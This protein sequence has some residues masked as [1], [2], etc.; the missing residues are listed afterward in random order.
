M[1]YQS[2]KYPEIKEEDRTYGAAISGEVLR[3][4]GDWRP[5]TPPD[6]NQNIRGIE[7][8]ACYVEA[9]QASIASIQE[10]QFDILDQN[11]SARFN[12]LLSGGDE[13]GGDPLKG[14]LSIKKDGLIPQKMMDFGDDIQSWLDFHSWKGVDKDKCIQEGKNEAS[15]WEKKYKIVAEKE[16]SLE[17][18]YANLREDLKR[19]PVPMS[20]SAWFERDGKY[21]KPKGMRDNH[22]VEALYVDEKNQITIRDTYSPYIKVLEAN[23]DFDFAMYWILRKKSPQEVLDGI[24]INLLVI[25]LSYVAKLFKSASAFAGEIISGTFTPKQG[26]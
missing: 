12:A 16:D 22:L 18:K 17:S 3:G 24:K 1:K 8:S 15:Q 26:D 4:G 20:V 2:F 5:F 14:A 25:L 9:Q 19:A 11:Y 21:Y 10:E 6:E 23:T 13:S 7:S